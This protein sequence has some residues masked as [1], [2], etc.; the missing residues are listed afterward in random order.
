MPLFMAFASYSVK[1]IL[2]S[3]Y[4]QG[5]RPQ[6]EGLAPESVSHTKNEKSKEKRIKLMLVQKLGKKALCHMI[7]QVCDITVPAC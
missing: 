6:Q 4:I 3:R 1:T 7:E 2:F 5:S